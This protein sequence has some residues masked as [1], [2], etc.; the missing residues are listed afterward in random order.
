MRLLRTER[1]PLIYDHHTYS[2]VTCPACGKCA[3]SIVHLLK[4][5]T[6]TTKLRKAH[7]LNTSTPHK[8]ML[9]EPE[10]VL[11]FLIAAD[12]SEDKESDL[13]VIVL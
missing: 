5:C 8:L 1:H 6:A 4:S 3:A 2:K 7:D 9:R 10:R 13:M 11:R 12:L